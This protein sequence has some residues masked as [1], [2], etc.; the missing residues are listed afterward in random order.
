MASDG[1]PTASGTTGNVVL[2]PSGGN[3]Q[4]GAEP[5]PICLADS[6]EGSRPETSLFFL[7]DVSDSMH[8][9]VPEFSMCDS[10]PADF[11]FPNRWEATRTAIEAFFDA[12]ESAGL[13]SGFSFFP[14]ILGTGA[15]CNADHYV[16]PTE[17][18]A[19]L[20]GAATQLKERLNG[21]VLDGSTPTKPALEGAISYAREWST[22]RGLPVAVVL[23]TDGYPHTCEDQNNTIEG[24]AEVARAAY[25]ATP[26]I[27][28]YVLGVG[29]GLDELDQV[30]EAGGTTQAVIADTTLDDVTS[31]LID[32]LD[33]IRDEVFLNCTYTI[34]DP[35]EGQ[36]LDFDLVNVRYTTADGE[37]ISILEDPTEGACREGWQY[38]Q[39]HTRIQ[40]CGE[41]CETVKQDFGGRLD[42]L[43]GC[44][45]Q[46]AAPK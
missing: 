43:F 21:L 45:T 16:I 27:P 39:D 6:R 3:G 7:V 10:D 25:L 32:A 23:A 22:E 46:V 37:E 12:P 31:Q 44:Q 5:D 30:A 11:G 42:V 4:G 15:D 19:Q 38:T 26:S 9:R 24:T 41:A 1:T 35:P 18:M 17:E 34:P 8:C 13:W 14:H 29:S 28:I 36:D 40:L 20:P 33:L 2:I